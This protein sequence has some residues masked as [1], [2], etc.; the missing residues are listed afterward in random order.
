MLLRK[1]LSDDDGSASLEFVA[2]GT[3]LLVPLVYLVIALSVI[4]SQSLGAESA[5]RH[6]ARAIASAESAA[7]VDTRTQ[8][9][10]DA[11]VSEYGIDKQSLTVDVQCTPALS[12]CPAAG[13]TVLVSVRIAV[14]LPMAPALP[15][16]EGFARVPV[17]AT[18][19]QKVSRFWG[20]G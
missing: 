11:T 13:A 15:G 14:P 20:E 19:V 7:D 10:L 6:I 9:V 2:L 1:P 8:A 5:A 3:L 4:Q 16:L 18:A 17:E 12:P